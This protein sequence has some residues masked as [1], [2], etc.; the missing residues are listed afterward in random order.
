MKDSTVQYDVSQEDVPKISYANLNVLCSRDGAEMDQRHFAT[1]GTVISGMILSFMAFT[2]SAIDASVLIKVQI[3]TGLFASTLQAFAAGWSAHSLEQWYYC[4]RAPC[5]YMREAALAQSNPVPTCSYK[6]GAAWN[7]QVAAAVSSFIALVLVLIASKLRKK[8]G[9]EMAVPTKA[10]PPSKTK[11]NHQP[12]NSA[13]KPQQDHSAKPRGPMTKPANVGAQ[14]PEPRNALPE[15]D[16]VFDKAS[17]LY[18]SENEKLFLHLESAMFYDPATDM[19]CN[20]ENN[21]WFHA[22]K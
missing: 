20:S 6:R 18:W 2:M 8:P 12:A 9:S 5:T 22:E 17:G 14:A 1:Q 13:A 11:E 19:W 3:V 15:G 16:W 4:N 21:E 10:T 7:L